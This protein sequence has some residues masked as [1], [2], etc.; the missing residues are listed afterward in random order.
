MRSLVLVLVLFLSSPA[1]ALNL[2]RVKTWSTSDIL[3][4]SDLNAE[5]DNILNHSLVNADISVSAAITASKIDF[6]VMSAVGATT[7]A[8][9]TFTTLSTNGDTTIGDAAADTLTVKANTIKFG[10]A[11]ADSIYTTLTVTDPTV[12]SKT[13]TIPNANSVTLPSGA[14]FYMLT[15]SCPPGTTDVSATYA[16]K[17]LKVNSTAGTSAGAVL[18]ATTDAH[19]ISQGELPSYNLSFTRYD[20]N[21]SGSTGVQ[22]TTNGATATTQNVSSSGSGT[23]FTMTISTPTTLEP[24]S[25]TAKLCQVD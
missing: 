19:T 13:V 8:G 22:G 20:G 17:Y 3:T 11:T 15:G 4:A 9:A 7:P 18:T 24:S 12:T 25:L 1:Y 23:S 2:S 21:G 16:N 10:G 6:S 5:F 14:A